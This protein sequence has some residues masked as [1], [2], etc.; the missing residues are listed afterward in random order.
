[1]AQTNWSYHVVGFDRSEPDPSLELSIQ[2][3]LL[4]DAMAAVGASPAST[5]RLQRQTGREATH[6]LANDLQQP[7]LLTKQG[8]LNC[9]EI[10]KLLPIVDSE[11]T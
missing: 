2:G 11:T 6:R 10:G 1:M 7:G 5:L 3:H 8:W 4:V 9:K